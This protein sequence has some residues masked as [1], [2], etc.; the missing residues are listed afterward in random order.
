MTRSFPT[1][2][3]AFLMTRSLFM[4]WMFRANFVVPECKQRLCGY[5]DFFSDEIFGEKAPAT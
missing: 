2:Q 4:G 1:R 3:D 5:L